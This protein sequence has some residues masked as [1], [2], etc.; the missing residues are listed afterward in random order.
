MGC[1]YKA[2]TRDPPTWR[3]VKAIN[4]KHIQD[5]HELLH[6]IDI[7]KSLDHPNII[8]MYEIYEDDQQIFIVQEY[9][10]GHHSLCEGG[11]LFQKLMQVDKFSEADAKRIFRQL[12]EA[13]YY[14]HNHR[15]AHRDLKPENILFLKSDSLDLKLIDFGVSFSWEKSMSGELA[16]KSKKNF[17]G[18]VTLGR[19]RRTMW[20]LKFS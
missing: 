13:V 14:C 7:L 1:V 6:E 20:L 10:S 4:K 12:V 19:F 8:K 18:T 16:A 11:E 5:Q 9:P 2:R 3:A 15:V 17:V